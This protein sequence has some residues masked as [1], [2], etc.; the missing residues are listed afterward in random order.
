VGHFRLVTSLQ[1]LAERSLSPDHDYTSCCLTTYRYMYTYHIQ[2]IK[3]AQSS[4]STIQLLMRAFSTLL[5]L[6]ILRKTSSYVISHGHVRTHVLARVSS[7]PPSPMQHIVYKRLWHWRSQRY[8]LT[9]VAAT[10]AQKSGATSPE[11]CNN[12]FNFI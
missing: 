7:R 1:R 12:V 9:K 11:Y 4:G 5:L 10:D 3:A 8:S 2:Y 6:R